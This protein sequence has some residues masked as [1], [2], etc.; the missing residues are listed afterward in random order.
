MLKVI[1]M[2]PKKE[3]IDL[4][5]PHM[6]QDRK[7]LLFSHRGVSDPDTPENSLPAIIQAGNRGYDMIELDVQETQDGQPVLFHDQTL[8]K[9]CG[10]NR[11]IRDL[12]IREAKAIRDLKG[13]QVLTTLDQACELC[14]SLNLGV[15]LDIKTRE[16]PPTEDFIK[17]IADLLEKYQLTH[18]SI[19]FSSHPTAR[20]YLSEKI[21]R[22]AIFSEEYT[23]AIGNQERIPLK[24]KIW[25]D[26]PDLLTTASVK[27]L[28]QEGAMVIIT[29]KVSGYPLDCHHELAREDINRFLAAG[30]DGFLIDTAF[31][32]FF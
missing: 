2:R 9:A 18:S 24:G 10:L 4:T 11:K 12:T 21:I 30:V 32:L 25:F 15:I 23:K 1:F 20:K 22:V 6:I 16:H 17:N 28:Q 3:I 31:D 8:E 5:N 19:A 29:L 7:P 14:Q 26:L 13:G 27:T